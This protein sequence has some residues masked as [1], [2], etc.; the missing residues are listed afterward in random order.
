M[1][2]CQTEAFDEAFAA[3]I[4]FSDFGFNY[5]ELEELIRSDPRLLETEE[6]WQ[7]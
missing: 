2:G 7:A 1:T 5:S 4:V 3:F 6:Q